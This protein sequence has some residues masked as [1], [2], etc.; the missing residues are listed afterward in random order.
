MASTKVLYALTGGPVTDL[1]VALAVAAIALLASIVSIEVGVSIAIVEILGG[2]L[3]ANVFHLHSVSWLDFLASFGS[4][5]LTFLAGAEV[6][7]DLMK[8]NLGSSVLIGCVSALAPFAAALLCARFALDW[9]WRA[10]EICGIALSTTSLAVVYAVLVETGLNRQRLGKLIMAATFVTDL[11]TVALLSVLFIKPNAWIFA[12][13]GASVL[14][15]VALPRVA[16]WFFRR[17]G[18]RVVEPEMKLIF[19]LLLGLMVLGKLSLSQAVLPAFLLGL[20]A[21]RLYQRHH[22][23]RQRLRVV[24][25]ALLTPAFF[26]RSGM[27]VSL[28]VL[29]ANA[30][31]LAALFAVKVAAKLAG[32]FP[33]AR[34][35]VGE[36]ST[37]FTLLMSTGLTFGTISALYGYQA[38][39]I[40]KTQFSLLVATV[41]LSAVVPTLVAQ[42]WFGPE[43][44]I[45]RHDAMS[46]LAGTSPAEDEGGSD[47]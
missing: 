11:G 29:W 35:F 10:A 31:L 47:V 12:F 39:I 9:N 38:G 32:V 7:I 44:E 34:R 30:G 1:Y 37:Y 26:I 5:V 36:G 25:F 18:D 46:G 28:G 4:I 16:P 24:A 2:V 3:V 43:Q 45:L 27:N 41:V 42:R 22:K 21:S 14:A 20:V 17:Y 19:V 33:L 40:D 8:E 6:D 23:E 15:I 13:V